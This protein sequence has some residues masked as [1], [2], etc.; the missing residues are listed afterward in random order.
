MK[1]DGEHRASW[2]KRA[3]KAGVAA[4]VAGVAVGSAGCLSRP[5]NPL[6]PTTT[7]TEVE[8][9]HQ[10]A[11]DKIDV[12]LMIDNSA[13][14]ADKQSILGDAVSNLVTG[15][16][17]PKCLLITDLTQ[18]QSPEPTDP[19]VKCNPGYQR[20]FNP[21]FDVHIGIVTSSLGG[22][23]SNSCPTDAADNGNPTN[24]DAGHLITRGG[25]GY[26]ND[27]LFWNPQPKMGAP[28]GGI[29]DLPTLAKDLSDGVTGAGQNG[30]GYEAS[31]EAWYRFLVDPVPYTSIVFG[32]DHVVHQSGTDSALLQQRADFMR[33]DSLLAII[34]LSDENDC[35]IKEYSYYPIVANQ[36]PLSPPPVPTKQCATNPL[37][38]CCTSC[39]LVKSGDKCFGGSGCDGMGG[40]TFTQETDLVNLRCF[41]TKKRYGVDFLYPIERYTLALSEPRIPDPH[42]GDGSNTAGP[43]VENP[44]FTDLNKTGASVRDKSLVFIAG[45]VGV[46]WEDIA[47]N[48]N[49]LGDPKNPGFKNDAQ[50]NATTIKGKDG[51]LH[52]TW[53]VILGDPDTFIE[54]LDPHMIESQKPRTGTD[55][56][57]GTP[58]A[59]VNS[60]P[61]TD[62]I[63][64]H[65]WDTGENTNGDL[66]YACVFELPPPGKDCK[67]AGTSCDCPDGTDPNI[68]STTNPLCDTTTITQQVRAKGYPGLRELQVLKSV[69]PQGIVGSICPATL[70]GDTTAIEYGYNAAVQGIID[71]LKAKLGNSCLAETFHPFTS[72]QF[73]G[74]VPCVIIEASKP[75]DCAAQCK[76]LGHE[77]VESKYK[78]A[79]PQIQEQDKENGLDY[80][81]FCE[82]QQADTTADLTSCL[83]DSDSN[84]PDIN[85]W[86][87]VDAD[88]E[89]VNVSLVHDCPTGRK[90]RLR[91]LGGTADQSGTVYVTCSE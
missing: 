53:D 61:G 5:I 74:Q 63:N 21:V 76:S 59:G 39:G 62:K 31:I 68:T 75:A 85:R 57:T 6:E 86:C 60:P 42:Q 25:M 12:L 70:M 78:A 36:A 48:P 55:P 73:R 69:G 7:T 51:K 49:N 65:E 29:T 84:P 50:M 58:M 91:F 82:L 32:S 2:W 89:S 81:C 8:T 34:M 20:E 56:I 46:P 22:H 3:A 11:V 54:P 64:G 18:Q 44:I 38:A 23:G 33:A 35:S 9:L 13:S 66:Q 15:L 10:T 16:L 88:V 52:S 71:R 40:P 17:N 45:I 77:A 67:T 87:Y 19:T 30:C 26:T 83:N 47:V 80:D 90:R 1:R 28:T 14:M 24:D 4:M 72:G 41:E 27:F 37:D 43:L 79:I